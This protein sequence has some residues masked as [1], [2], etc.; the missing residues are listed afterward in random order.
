MKNILF[1]TST[2]LASNPRIVKEIKSCLE[3]G[4]NIT[5]I[6]FEFNNWSSD[7]DIE[8][9]KQLSSVQFYILSA[10]R[11]PFFQFLASVIQE[12][13]FRFLSFYFELNEKLLSIAL[14]RSSVLL[15]RNIKKVRTADLII[16]HNSAA[17][18]P[19]L[20]AAKKFSAK[21]IF[22]FE[23]YHRGELLHSHWKSKLISNLENKCVPYFDS[24]TAASPLISEAYENVFPGKKIHIINNY[25][26]KAYAKSQISVIE[27]TPIKLFWFSQNIGND[28]GLEY[29]IEALKYFSNDAFVLTLLGN[30][31]AENL[32]Y[33]TNI[34]LKSGL[35]TNQVIFLHPVKEDEI[36][37]IA[38]QHHIGIAS[39]IAHVQ[40]RDYCLT[41]KVFMYLLSGNAVLMS[42]TKAQK[43]FWQNHQDVGFCYEQQNVKSIVGA[44]EF[45]KSNPGILLRHR[46]NALE[47]AKGK[48]N[49]ESE[50][51]VFIN[52]IDLT[53]N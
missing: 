33:F 6:C 4:C 36:C 34:I 50:Q 20:Y 35:A 5:V 40:N 8:I 15:L 11:K 31:S 18:Y 3:Y 9:R 37:K 12:K 46:E 38:S 21:S 26:S 42:D 47:L 13:I 10:Y 45:Y 14:S 28:R 16:G 32:Q 43:L 49:W 17:M 53:L 2:N 48:M 51:E 41:N 44:L 30:C 29:I 22:D 1:I 52:N 24:I 39:E 25:F 7:S 19:T 23:D 27:Y